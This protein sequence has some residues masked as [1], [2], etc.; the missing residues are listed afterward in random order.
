MQEEERKPYVPVRINAIKRSVSDVLTA[1]GEGF[2][3]TGAKDNTA[4]DFEGGWG[5]LK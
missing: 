5:L 4:K 1:S 3:D 2:D